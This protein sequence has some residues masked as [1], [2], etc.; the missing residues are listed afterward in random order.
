MERIYEKP[1][2]NRVGD[3][4]S[5]NRWLFTQVSESFAQIERKN[6]ELAALNKEIEAFSYS[7]SHDLRGPLRS[8]DGFSARRIR[9]APLSA[10]GHAHKAAPERPVPGAVT[11]R[12][13]YV[14]VARISKAAMVLADV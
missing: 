1:K 8:M 12:L 14:C 3:A 2:L 10:A 13:L 6:D 9:E 11:F 5:T 4:E 7:V